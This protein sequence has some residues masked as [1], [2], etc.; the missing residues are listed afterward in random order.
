MGHVKLESKDGIAVITLDDDKTMNAMTMENVCQLNDA[1]D[2]CSRSPEVR[3][4]ILTGAGK[5]AF[6]SGGDL[7]SEVRYATY[8]HENIERYNRIGGDLV[9]GIMGSPV[10][11]IA[12]VNGYALGAALGLI[13]ACDIA[14]ASENA[15]FGL[16]TASLGGIPGWGCTQTVA[17]KLG[18]QEALRM[19]LLNERIDAARAYRIGLVSEI[20]PIEELMPRVFELAGIIA[21]SPPNAM[22]AVKQCVNRGLEGSLSNGFG[23]EAELLKETNTKYNFREGIAAFLEKRTPV[24]TMKR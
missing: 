7:K 9:K 1:V 4:V 22:G 24:F 23:I 2:R 17:R 12:A 3:C 21:A 10:P 19:L 16:P 15:V 18:A 5:K 13:A 8:E 14:V 11:F 6:T 20:V